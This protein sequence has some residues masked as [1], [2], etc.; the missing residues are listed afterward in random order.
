[1]PIDFTTW[2]SRQANS[3]EDKSEFIKPSQA[4]VELTDL[5]KRLLFA[6]LLV[7]NV[8]T[9]NLLD[10]W[11]EVFRTGVEGNAYGQHQ[12]LPGMLSSLIGED[13]ADEYYNTNGYYR[14]I[15]WWKTLK[16]DIESGVLR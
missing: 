5:Q 10:V 1:M 7:P 2:V 12:V 14:I 13:R 15:L 16:K 4:S 9:E 6:N 11:I 3:I 8:D